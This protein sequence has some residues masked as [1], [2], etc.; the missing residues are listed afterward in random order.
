MTRRGTYGLV[1]GQDDMNLWLVGGNEAVNAVLPLKW[2]TIGVT[3]RVKGSVE[4]YTLDSNG[5]PILCQ[6]QVLFEARPNFYC[7]I[8]Y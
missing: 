5:M 4:L 2:I 6:T 8:Q 3:N 1:L 7:E